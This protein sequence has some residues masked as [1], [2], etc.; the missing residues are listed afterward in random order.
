MA[1]PMGLQFG[2]Y[3]LTDSGVDANVS[4]SI[5]AYALGEHRTDGIFYIDYIGRSDVNLAARLKQHVTEPSPHFRFTYCPSAKAA[6]E[7][8]C[9]L[10]HDFTPPKNKVHPARP[11]NSNWSC[12]RCTIFH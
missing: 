10:Y 7:K 2:P 1:K 12:P 4:A 3:P 6:F 11:Q 9:N 5:G 8:E